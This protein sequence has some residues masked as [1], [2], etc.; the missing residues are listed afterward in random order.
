VDEVVLSAILSLSSWYRG[1]EVMDA[2]L[3]VRSSDGILDVLCEDR[4]ARGGG[5]GFL[6]C[7]D[8]RSNLS[9]LGVGSRDASLGAE[10]RASLKAPRGGGN[11]GSGRLNSPDVRVLG[12]SS[13]GLLI[14]ESCSSLEKSSNAIICGPVGT[15]FPCL[16]RGSGGFTRLLCVLCGIAPTCSSS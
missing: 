1:L 15:N 3:L 7:D 4:R 13:T 6:D 10:A 5:G 2:L 14:S 8:G 12:F 11:G 9:G 16:C